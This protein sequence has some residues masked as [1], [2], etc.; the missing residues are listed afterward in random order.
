MLKMQKEF[1]KFNDEK[2]NNPKKLTKKYE[3][4]LYQRKTEIPKKHM[5]EMFNISS[6]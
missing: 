6:H 5:K 4:T 3:P 1:L 2:K